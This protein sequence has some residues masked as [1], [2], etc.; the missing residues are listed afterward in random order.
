MDRAEIRKGKERVR[1]MLIT[2]LEADGMCRT[3]KTVS[4]HEAFLEKVERAACY[5]SPEGLGTLRF[6]VSSMAK[7]CSKCGR[8]EGW[9][10]VQAIRSQAH[11]I[12]QPPVELHPMIISYMK[13]KA[14]QWAWSQSEDM[15]IALVA[16]MSQRGRV[17][18]KKNGGW[19]V[20]SRDA[21]EIRRRANLRRALIKEDR[22]DQ[23]DRDAQAR[24]EAAKDRA[25]D[26]V[27]GEF[28]QA[29]EEAA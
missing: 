13:S 3:K 2:P 11:S 1:D 25:R 8:R 21:E 23:E 7:L 22:A 10:S 19:S 4:E 14:G 29:E 26:L 28:D 16:Y 20:V 5:M 17:P 6:A 18:D 15:A 9:P 24:Y 27:F 12:E